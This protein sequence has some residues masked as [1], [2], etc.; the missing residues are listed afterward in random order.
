MFL[1]LTNSTLEATQILFVN[2]LK[3]GPVIEPAR[4]LVHWFIGRTIGSLVE[5]HD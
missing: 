2:V 5:P 1:T 3:T 4:V